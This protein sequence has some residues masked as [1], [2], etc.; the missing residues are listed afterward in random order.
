MEI[1]YLGPLGSYS[2]EAIIALINNNNNKYHGTTLC[3][4]S[5]I[6]EMFEKDGEPTFIIPLENALSGDIYDTYWGLYKRSFVVLD[7]INIKIEH[8]LY[9]LKGSKLN[10]I[11]K[12]YSHPQALLQATRFFSENRIKP[13]P[14]LSSSDSL[15]LINDLKDKSCGALASKT[16]EFKYDDLHIINTNV[17]NNC[18]NYTR[19]LLIKLASINNYS[20][21]NN[22]IY[23][24][25]FSLF[26]V[27]TDEA[28]VLSKILLI[29]SNYNIN[30]TNIKSRNIEGKEFSYFFIVE[31]LLPNNYNDIHY[32]IVNELKLFTKRLEYSIF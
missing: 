6:V 7:S 20:F 17:S 3:N 22:Y 25:L 11:K 24:K 29:F 4:Y 31:G 2:Y 32:L 15:I 21:D 8:S 26:E 13:K 30:L 16:L 10:D 14:C 19:F 18:N 12:V 1:G 9:A 5:S 27:N 23:T 28:G